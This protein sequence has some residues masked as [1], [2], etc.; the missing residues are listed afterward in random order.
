M[1]QT[2]SDFI[3]EI[4]EHHERWCAE[5]S[6]LP[7]TLLFLSRIVGVLSRLDEDSKAK[8]VWDELTSRGE[9]LAS[10]RDLFVAAEAIGH[11]P[12]EERQLEEAQIRR[13]LGV[14]ISEGAELHKVQALHALKFIASNECKPLLE[15][16][17]EDESPWVQSTAL[18]TYLR[19]DLT[20]KTQRGPVADYLIRKFRESL[21]WESINSDLVSETFEKY[22]SL[23]K[24]LIINLLKERGGRRL[25]FLSVPLWLTSIVVTIIIVIVKVIGALLG[26]A[27]VVPVGLAVIGV[28]LAFV[29]VA[30]VLVAVFGVFVAPLW[31]RSFGNK[32]SETK[33]PNDPLLRVVGFALL[34]YLLLA[35][36]ILLGVTSG[37]V[38]PAITLGGFLLVLAISRAIQEFSPE[39]AERFRSLMG[40]L[41]AGWLT[42]LAIR[43]SQHVAV[44]LTIVLMAVQG[45]RVSLWSAPVLVAIM[46]WTKKV[47]VKIPAAVSWCF[48]KLREGSDELRRTV[49][50]NVTET[51]PATHDTPVPATTTI[52]VAVVRR[53]VRPR[54]KHL[55]IIA[56]II[57]VFSALV[58]LGPS[59][60]ERLQPKL[61]ALGPWLLNA[62]LTHRYYLYTAAGLILLCCYCGA[63]LVCL[64]FLWDEVKILETIRLRIF[65]KGDVHQD[66]PKDFVASMFRSIRD[67]N[68]TTALRVQAVSTLT[69]VYPRTDE[70]YLHTLWNLSREDLPRG[71]KDAIQKAVADGHKRQFQ[72]RKRSREIDP[73]KLD[74]AMKQWL[75]K[76]RRSI[77]RPKIE[78]ALYAVLLLSLLATAFQTFSFIGSGRAIDAVALFQLAM[79][80]FLIYRFIRTGGRESKT[81]KWLF[82]IALML[83]TVGITHPLQNFL[84]DP[85]WPDLSLNF[86]LARID[87][88]TLSALVVPT[89]LACVIAQI[90]HTLY[91]LESQSPIEVGPSKK[92]NFFE[93]RMNRLGAKPKVLHKVYWLALMATVVQS[94]PMQELLDLRYENMPVFATNLND[95]EFE[96]RNLPTDGRVVRVVLVNVGPEPELPPA[97]DRTLPTL[98]DAAVSRI[99]SNTET[100]MPALERTFP[101]FPE[102]ATKI[103]KEN[104]EYRTYRYG[105]DIWLSAR[106][107][108]IEIWEPADYCIGPPRLV[109][110]S[111][112]INLECIDDYN[113]LVAMVYNKKRSDFVRRS[114]ENPDALLKRKIEPP[115]SERRRVHTLSPFVRT[116]WTPVF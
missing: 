14:V 63:A 10:T 96:L 17:L 25:L 22:F 33:E 91:F 15:K 79:G 97:Y 80:S 58:Y 81:R 34:D 93:R 41:V 75:A 5:H 9:S 12:P 3:L 65:S 87:S 71:V 106:D 57:A 47:I 26:L 110:N 29:A 16:G 98:Y 66:D 56:S 72:S 42:W 90:G 108:K 35:A 59:V 24:G 70:G 53:Y 43:W 89:I 54:P 67:E 1:T 48:Q 73:Q 20:E 60:A 112:F 116:V 45:V 111:V 52:A 19:L 40:F 99:N 27:L 85:T 113:R 62:P 109:E 8:S 7:V 68:L 102:A 107:G 6:D 74:E 44:I 39:K 55:I 86:G 11:L 95:K 37:I 69:R 18:R 50:S 49:H 78:R 103:L 82:M 77:L 92:T 13:E 105:G 76:R 2:V 30:L 51:E 101:Y 104:N 88:P 115:W 28:F 64:S 94:E 21:S 100:Y 36:T 61:I 114:S 84:M 46:A 83:L 32:P 38:P 31:A 4:E 23:N